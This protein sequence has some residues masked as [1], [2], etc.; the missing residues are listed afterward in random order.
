MA[1]P[2]QPSCKIPG[3]ALKTDPDIELSDAA[4]PDK[5]S[6]ALSS[7]GVKA[8]LLLQ[9]A[10]VAALFII[11]SASDFLTSSL[12]E[13]YH[14]VQ[15]LVTI[16]R[17][18]LIALLL[19]WLLSWIGF[20]VCERLPLRWKRAAWLVPLVALPWL[21]CRDMSAVFVLPRVVRVGV[22]AMPW[23]TPVAI[24]VFLTLLLLRPR[25][26]DWCIVGGRFVYMVA[27]FSLLI[28]L[29]KVVFHAIRFGAHEQSSFARSGIPVA[30][31]SASRI[32]WILMDE[33]SYDQGFDHRQPDVTLPNFDAF[34]RSSVVFSA[35]QPV[36]KMTEDVLPALLLGKPIVDFRKPYG[37]LP[38]YR[39]QP[40]GPWQR[41]DQYDTVFGDARRLG[42][43]TG[44]A[45]WY[46]PYCRLLPDVLDRCFWQYSEDSRT[47]YSRFLD[48]GS[49]TMRNL[50]VI[51]SFPPSLYRAF[52][53]PPLNYTQPHRQDY[54]DLL[55]QSKHL[56]HDARIRFVLLHLPVPHPPGIYD[57]ARKTMRDSG[58]YLDNLVLADVTLGV[59]LQ[60]IQST[61]AMKNTT[62]IVSS[63]H[64]WRTFIWKGLPGWSPEE[65]RVSGGEFEPR[66]ILMVRLPGSHD[67]QTIS[68]PTSAMFMHTMLEAM[69]RNQVHSDADVD[70]L[71][72][73]ALS[74]GQ[75]EMGQKK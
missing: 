62:V 4:P 19:I 24:V 7:E 65:Q 35:V 34:A 60:D 57:R 54:A 40:D 9:G 14:R 8:N 52:H 1:L 61:P 42:W 71:L 11:A 49:T 2:A 67:G 12:G 58:S 29:P 56:L 17:A 66:P 45:G 31:L 51:F 6:S 10:G 41:F 27:A 75:G 44:I 3:S 23:A 28:I 13:A 48:S 68:R 59:L 63:D 53:I 70:A 22:A 32:V 47:P 73:G 20:A 15:P 69:L 38:G 21:I 5:E 18:V 25:L 39:T 74:A 50:A 16:F 30:S 26:F 37:T 64:S 55:S 43:S 46:N 36:G 72:S 33:F